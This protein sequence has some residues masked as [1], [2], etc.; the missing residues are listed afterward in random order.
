M[1]FALAIYDP[2]DDI[3]MKPHI[4]SAA[5]ATDLMTRLE[6]VGY[7]FVDV[8]ESDADRERRRRALDAV[9]LQRR[10]AADEGLVPL[11][12]AVKRRWRNDAELD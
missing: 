6:A 7:S 12:E 4:D 9:A 3:V 11:K 10:Q 1:P 5:S 2:R 8:T